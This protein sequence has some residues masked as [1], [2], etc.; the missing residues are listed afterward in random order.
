VTV[1]AAR[2]GFADEALELRSANREW[3][4]LSGNGV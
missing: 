1:S 2:V 4:W 3:Q